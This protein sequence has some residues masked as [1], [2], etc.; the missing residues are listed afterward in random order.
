MEK[1][2]LCLAILRFVRNIGIITV[3]ILV[4]AS[5]SCLPAAWRTFYHLGNRAVLLGILVMV[6]GVFPAFNIGAAGDHQFLM[7]TGDQFTKH[8]LVDWM[9]SF[10]LTITMGIAGGVAAFLG[11]LIRRA[12]LSVLGSP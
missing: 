4:L 11:D 5:L 7:P 12:G 1:Q 3:C 10:R 8:R 2:G 6:L 9:G